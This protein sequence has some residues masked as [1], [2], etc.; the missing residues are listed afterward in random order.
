VV[1][2]LQKYRQCKKWRYFV[3]KRRIFLKHTALVGGAY[4]LSGIRSLVQAK[5]TAPKNKRPNI[6][7][8]ISDDASYPHTGAYGCKWIKTPGF[9]RVAKEG[10]LFT[11]AYTPNAKCA[12]SRS[13]IL[14]G[15]NSWQLEEAANHFPNFPQ[16][17]KT[18][19]ETLLENGYHV[20]YTGKGWAPGNPGRDKNGRPRQLCGISYQKKKTKPPTQ[21]IAPCDYSA[22]FED[23][24]NKC[25]NDKPFCFWYGG[26]EPHRRY[27]F[28]SGI[29]KGDKKLSDV[30]QIYD[31][32]PDNETVRTDILDYAFEVEYFDQHLVRML[33]ILE[34]KGKLD[35]T[36]VIVTSDNGMPFPRIKGQEYEYSNHLPLAIMWKKYITNP[37]RTVDDFVSFID[38]APTFLELSGV[39][40]KE[41]GMHKIQGK[42][43]LPI[44]ASDKSGVVDPSRDHVLIGKERHDVGRPNDCGYPIRGIIKGNLLY[45]YNVENDRWPAGNP[46]TGYLNC[47]GS[48][49]KTEILNDRR[50]NGSSVFWNQSFGKRP[51][52]ELYNIAKDPDCLN[53]LAQKAEYEQIKEQIKAQLFTE[54]EEQGDP[55]IFGKGYI[56]D[57]YQYSDTRTR[58]FYERYMRGDK[59]RAKWV[60]QSDSEK[61]PLD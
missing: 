20:G 54:L 53:N 21:G 50:T 59:I 55:R 57:D 29:R 35:N 5:S 41:S 58:G 3:M 10:I 56:F 9:D 36:V 24:L 49:T 43:L 19:A 31:F 28:E 16:K 4:S 39:D 30:D 38:F 6:L 2:G 26:R 17:F 51:A 45:I 12:P 7:F 13:C 1:D 46:E 48:P 33:N 11:R 40:E 25:Q 32:W 8:C 18:Y 52:E 22:N 61:Q 23:F 14:T 42:S 37:G 27:E 15:R 60:N 47:D 34:E 44:F